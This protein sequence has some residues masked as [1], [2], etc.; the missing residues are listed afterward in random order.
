MPG[1]SNN[2]FFTPSDFTQPPRNPADLPARVTEVH[3][4][5]YRAACEHGEVWVRLKGSLQ[6]D[7]SAVESLPTVG[8]F[9]YLQYDPQGQSLI[10]QLLPRR[11]KFSRFDGTHSREQLVAANFDYV[12]IATSLNFDF[13]LARVER[14]LAAAWQSGAQPVVVLT[15]ADLCD[16]TEELIFRVEQIAPGVPVHAVS[17]VTGAGIDQ[18]EPYLQPGLAL[19]LLGMSG[20]GKSSLINVLLGE[21][22][23]EVR[24]IRE[25]DSRGRHTTT[26]RQLLPL[27]CGALVID[28]PG[29]REMGLWG[30]DSGLEE[31]FPDIE[32]LAAACRFR[33]CTHSS[34]PGCAV[35][36]ALDDG[37]L[38]QKRY[39]SYCALVREAARH[40]SARTVLPAWQRK[41][42]AKAFAKSVKKALESKE[43]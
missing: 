36:A 25:D 6:R 18:L 20:V 15:K 28:T 40:A 22:R 24:E 39:N 35:Q 21:E 30:V 37:S 17:A 13:N 33:D 11:T 41:Q 34:E 42:Q 3:K 8:D 32:E 29:M 27:P 38:E 31:T 19:A 4:E 43:R 10:T 9:V 1:T 12:W 2:P 23:L 7:A 16:R 14:Y 5:M 26:H